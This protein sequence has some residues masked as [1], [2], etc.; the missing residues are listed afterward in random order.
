MK[1]LLVVLSIMFMLSCEKEPITEP[2]IELSVDVSILPMEKIMEYYVQWAYVSN[3]H[4]YGFGF[5]V[6]FLYDL[7]E[8]SV[9]YVYEANWEHLD[10][11]EY[12]G[13]SFFKNKPY[14]NFRVQEIRYK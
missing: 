3:P 8:D 14:H 10:S 5:K 4:P 9:S 13:I 6:T 1:M 7:D 12:C 11:G 2:P